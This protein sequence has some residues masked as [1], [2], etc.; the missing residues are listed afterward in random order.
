M[1]KQK[2]EYTISKLLTPIAYLFPIKKNRVIFKSYDLKYNCN[3]KYMCEFLNKNHK[4]EFELIYV[5]QNDNNNALFKEKGIKYCNIK[6]LKYHYYMFTSRF[7]FINQAY[8]EYLPKKKN[9][10]AIFTD[11][12]VVL[13]KD[14]H[15]SKEL[16]KFRYEQYKKFDKFLFSSK[17]DAKNGKKK[18]GCTEEKVFYSGI[19]RVS[20]FFNPTFNSCC[21]KIVKETL[22][23]EQNKKLILYAPTFRKGYQK[24][25]LEDDFS[26]IISAC[27]Q[28]FGGEF[29][30]LN[31][32]HNFTLLNNN[33]KKYKANQKIYECNIIE[34]TQELVGASDVIISDYS[35]II[36][37]ASFSKNPCFLY[38]YDYEEYTKTWSF[39]T[40]INKWPFPKSGNIDDFCNLILK[41]D[42]EEYDK[43]IK[44]FYDFIGLYEN[45]TSCEQIYKYMITNK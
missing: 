29:V 22:G 38:I 6:S 13:F 7:I 5:T 40:D 19:P 41:Y 26:K 39:L 8:P 12:G 15:F 18:F 37:D 17:L 10:I 31:R 11:H 3:T 44:D 21:K 27:E 33:D 23:I 24:K 43:K 20:P 34:D 16:N 9:Q 14:P 42:E 4:N 32:D 35:S 25:F 2:I 1:I 30:I 45:G 36:W 28:R